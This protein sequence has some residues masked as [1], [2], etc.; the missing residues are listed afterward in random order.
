MIHILYTYHN[1]P[2]FVLSHTSNS[3][4][5][6]SQVKETNS[7]STGDLKSHHGTNKFLPDNSI[8]LHMENSTISQAILHIC[9]HMYDCIKVDH[10]IRLFMN[11]YSIIVRF[12]SFQQKNRPYFSCTKC[13]CFA[14][15]GASSALA[16]MAVFSCTAVIHEHRQNYNHLSRIY[17]GIGVGIRALLCVL[18]ENFSSESEVRCMGFQAPCISDLCPRVQ[19]CWGKPSPSRT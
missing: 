13:K 17:A 15:E 2:S 9:E 10:K 5:E 3:S 4:I 18:S 6:G 12:F 1:H 7:C 14:H 11:Y 8:R 19:A 16:Q